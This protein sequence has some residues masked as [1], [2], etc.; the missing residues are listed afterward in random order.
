MRR[1][2][3][4]RDVDARETSTTPKTRSRHVAGFPEFWYSWRHLMKEFS[5]DYY[6]VAIDQR[7]YNISS[8]PAKMTD[9]K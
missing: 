4:R 7:G 1:V 6:C 5:S 9:Y 8:K 2:R 3:A